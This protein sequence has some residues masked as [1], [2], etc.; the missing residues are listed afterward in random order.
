MIQN[1]VKIKQ[2]A[3]IGII[4]DA[5]GLPSVFV[6]SKVPEGLGILGILCGILLIGVGLYLI[7]GKNR[8]K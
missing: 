1:L 4:G 5:D 8:N 3:T 7:F 2:R 6:A